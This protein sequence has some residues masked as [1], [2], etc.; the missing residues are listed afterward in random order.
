MWQLLF[1]QEYF[2]TFMMWHFILY[3]II[4]FNKNNV[5]NF[6]MANN[7][8]LINYT[9]TRIIVVNIYNLY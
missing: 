7:L 3:Y 8:K 4:S 2:L 5:Q 1:T 9:I 6:K